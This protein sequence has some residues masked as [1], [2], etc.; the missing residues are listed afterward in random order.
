MP[1]FSSELKNTSVFTSHLR[2]YF[3]RLHF[4]KFVIVFMRSGSTMQRYYTKQ[5][6]C[7]SAVKQMSGSVSFLINSLFFLFWGNWNAYMA[8]VKFC[9]CRNKAASLLQKK[10]NEKLVKTNKNYQEEKVGVSLPKQQSEE[11]DGV[12]FLLEFNS[13]L[14]FLISLTPLFLF[15][16]RPI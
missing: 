2:T 11:N 10:T 1:W 7:C 4:I 13:I 8:A 6:C 9:S 12:W 5:S 15:I 14:Q 3:P 16:K